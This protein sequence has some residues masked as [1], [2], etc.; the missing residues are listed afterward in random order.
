MPN[1]IKYNTGS[2]P[3]NAIKS[4]NFAIGVNQGGYG[5][6]SITGYWNGKTPNVSG[7]TIY[8]A[9]GVSSPTIYVAANDAQLIAYSNQLGGSGITTVYGALNYFNSSSTLTCVDVDVSSIVTSGLTL[10]LDAGFTPSYPKGGTTWTNLSSSAHTGT[11][12]NGPVYDSANG[13]SISFDGT[14]DYMSVPSLSGTS[15]P[16]TTGT[17]SLWYYIDSTA[18]M[19]QSI[20]DIY[21]VD[22]RNHYFISSIGSTIYAGAYYSAGTIPFSFS[23]GVSFDNWNHLVLTYNSSGTATLYIN[24]D[25]FGYSVPV[26]GFQPSGQFVGFGSPTTYPVKGKSFNLMIYN[27]VLSQTEVLQNYYAGLQR[28]I[29][30]DNLVLWLDGQNT[31]TNVIDPTTAND[32]SGNNYNGTFQNGAKLSYYDAVRTFYFDGI[33]DRI[34][35]SVNTLALSTTWT[36]WVKRTQSMGIDNMI[37]GMSQ[38]YFSFRSNGDILFSNNI[39]GGLVT[40]SSSQNLTDNVWYYMSFVSSNIIGTTKMKIYINGSFVSETSVIYGNQPT[41]TVDSFR[42]GN[43]DTSGSYPF[44]G[45]IGD[46]RLYNRELTSTE[47]NYIYLAGIPRYGVNRVYSSYLILACDLGSV[48]IYSTS[49]DIVNYNITVGMYLYTNPALTIPLVTS[50]L[51]VDYVASPQYGQCYYGN[52]GIETDST[53]LVVNVTGSSYQCP[54]CG[55]C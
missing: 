26:G 6:T 52:S 19:Y 23:Y 11:L 46:V 13:G 43:S 40:L 20:F 22:G 8:Q 48:V 9:N 47:I 1:V 28:L 53:G 10:N 3:T 29:P 54:S 7:Y 55:G 49:Q 17:I 34:L 4:G 2:T 21:A 16:Q 25:N 41:T 36:V 39:N 38:P 33:N 12:I 31:N 15:F 14:N 51:G 37:M 50:T 45:K 18:T 27:R 30:T 32:M 24:G 5:P 35:T 44:N 42:L